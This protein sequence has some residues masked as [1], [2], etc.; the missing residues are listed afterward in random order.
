MRAIVADVDVVV[1]VDDDVDVV[2]YDIL[3]PAVGWLWPSVD[4]DDYGDDDGDDDAM[5]TKIYFCLMGIIYTREVGGG[6]SAPVR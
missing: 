6:I 2:V 5:I 3:L 4:Y 1:V